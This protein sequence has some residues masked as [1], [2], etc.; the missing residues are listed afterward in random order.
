MQVFDFM[1]V[2]NTH[3]TV[4]SASLP[5]GFMELARS[6]ANWHEYNVFTDPT[7]D[8]LGNS[9]SGFVL[10]SWMQC[11]ILLTV[12]IR[13]MLPSMLSAMQQITNSSSGL[14]MHYSAISYIPFMSFFNMT[15]LV[16]NGYIDGGIGEIP[17]TQFMF[18]GGS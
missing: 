2:M 18:A 6:I 15:G 11:S 7:F 5:S 9:T 10:F 17:F 4:F 16:E 13:T 12:G 3:D 14:K 1:S 8:G